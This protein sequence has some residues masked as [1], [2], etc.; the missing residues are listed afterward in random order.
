MT[1][2]IPH[3]FVLYL[4]GAT[5]EL[6]IK[7]AT[8]VSTWRRSD[9]VA[10]FALP[11]CSVTSG[12]PRMSLEGAR[13]MGAR[14][15]LI[16]TTPHG[17]MLHPEDIAPIVAAL[18][19]GYIVVS[20]LHEK[21]SE[22]AEVAQIGSRVSERIIELRHAFDRKPIANG[23]R[24]T[25][26]RVLTVGTDCCVGKMFTAL[27]ITREFHERGVEAD[28]RATGQTGM[29]IAGAGICVDAVT[30]DFVAGAAEILSPDNSPGHWD[31]IEGQGSLFHPAYAGVSLGLLHGSQPDA[32]VICHDH[33]RRTMDGADNFPAPSIEDV[34]DLNLACGR[35]TNPDAR[36]TGVALN[37]RGMSEATA[38]VACEE[39]EARLGLPCADPMRH[40]AGH[41]VAGLLAGVPH[42]ARTEA[43]GDSL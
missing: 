41:L 36:V 12:L 28:F 33:R 4:G 21:L 26:L 3:P 13:R 10:E 18:R 29:M 25:G 19:E 27:A 9:C 35:L 34:I 31:I 20:G 15:F 14:S 17:G 11:G 2:T 1:V 42:P 23:R 5:E 8:G 37:T 24:R 39:I 38:S 30:A 6:D 22:N 40:G 43:M 7:T 32:L 16:G